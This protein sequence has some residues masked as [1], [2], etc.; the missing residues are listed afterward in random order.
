[1]TYV[2]LQILLRAEC[3]YNPLNPASFCGLRK[4]SSTLAM[5][6]TAAFNYINNKFTPKKSSSKVSAAKLTDVISTSTSTMNLYAITS[7]TEPQVSQGEQLLCNLLTFLGLLTPCSQSRMSTFR[8]NISVI[9]LIAMSLLAFFYE[10][11]SN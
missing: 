3:A 1:M 11:V 4:K 8:R 5:I 7:V 2:C 6:P 9:V 10:L